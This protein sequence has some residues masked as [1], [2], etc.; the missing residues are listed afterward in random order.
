MIAR[1]DAEPEHVLHG[2]PGDD[3][4]RRNIEDFAEPAIG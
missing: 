1:G 2:H 4:L 3:E